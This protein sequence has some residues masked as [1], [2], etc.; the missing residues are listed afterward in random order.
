MQILFAWDVQTNQDPE[1][2]RQIAEDAT[3]DL[4]IRT[5]AV[6]IAKQTWDQIAV[7]DPWIEKLAPN[8]PPRRQPSVDRSLM[9]LAAWELINSPTPPKVV[10]AEAIEMAKQFSTEQ[11]A[12]FINAVLDNLLKEHVSLIGKAPDPTPQP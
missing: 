7:I 6:D 9:R 8:W 4:N 3:E 2:G 1:M 12:S 5:E 10:I 11:S